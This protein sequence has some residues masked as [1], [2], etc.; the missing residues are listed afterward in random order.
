M[1]LSRSDLNIVGITS[2]LI[3]HTFLVSTLL[4]WD[5][6]TKNPHWASDCQPKQ[7]M[8]KLSANPFEQYIY[9]FL[10]PFRDDLP[11]LTVQALASK[12]VFLQHELRR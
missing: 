4:N 3:I 12:C 5:Y 9:G 11:E 6:S 7:V 8:A 2:H 1:Y 10:A